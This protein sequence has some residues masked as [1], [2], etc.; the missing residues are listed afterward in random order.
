MTKDD[1]YEMICDTEMNLSEF[2]ISGSEYDIEA[3]EQYYSDLIRQL[4]HVAG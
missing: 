3:T 4:A 1:L 2:Y